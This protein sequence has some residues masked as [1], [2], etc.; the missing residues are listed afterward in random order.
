EIIRDATHPLATHDRSTLN[1]RTIK[2]VRYFRG[3]SSLGLQEALNRHYQKDLSD[4]GWV[5]LGGHFL[6]EF[7]DGLLTSTDPRNPHHPF[8]IRL[9]TAA[10]SLNLTNPVD[11]IR[12]HAESPQH[13]IHLLQSDPKLLNRISDEVKE[14]FGEGLVINYT[15][16][17]QVW[18]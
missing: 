1:F 5:T 7:I 9:L 11:V 13:Y 3:G 18:F 14:A 8:L 12:I 16:G 17:K 10:T 4:R 15:G 2:D 6:R